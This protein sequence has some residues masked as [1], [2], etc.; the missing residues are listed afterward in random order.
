MRATPGKGHAEVAGTV[1]T[2][3]DRRVSDVRVG[4]ATSATYQLNQLVWCKTAA[5]NAER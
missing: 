2:I 3:P 4:W 1:D 5:S